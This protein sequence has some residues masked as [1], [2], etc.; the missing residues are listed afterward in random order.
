MLVSPKPHHQAQLAFEVGK[1]KSSAIGGWMQWCLPRS[2]LQVAMATPPWP[3]QW[4]CLSNRPWVHLPC[5]AVYESTKLLAGDPQE[6][7]SK[8]GVQRSGQG[9]ALS[10]GPRAAGLLSV[11]QPLRKAALGAGLTLPTAGQGPGRAL[12]RVPI[13]LLTLPLKLGTK[14][15]LSQGAVGSRGCGLVPLGSAL[16]G[17]GVG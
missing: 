5:P 3:P 17:Q 6:M 9:H 12:P 4:S 15:P 8:A 14:M 1:T 10:P 16:P 2:T 13:W 11:H 7:F